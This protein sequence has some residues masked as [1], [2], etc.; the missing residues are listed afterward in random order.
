MRQTA[1]LRLSAG[2][3]RSVHTGPLGDP[4]ASRH[5]CTQVAVIRDGMKVVLVKK[6]AE[7]INGVDLTGHRAGDILDL[8][9]PKARLLVAEE[10][11]MPD[12]RERSPRTRTAA[13]GR[14]PTGCLSEVMFWQ[15]EPQQEL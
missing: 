12:R 13:G 4:V 3:S 10:W 5:T 7:Q 15:S 9:P 8:P 6:Y 14:L 2:R 1:A 11:A